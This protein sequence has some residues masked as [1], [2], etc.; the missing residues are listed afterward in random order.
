MNVFPLFYSLYLSFTD[1]SAIA[2]K[3][4]VWVGLAN[5]A[6]ILTSEQLWH[7]FNTTGKYALFTVACRSF[8]ALRWPCW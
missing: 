4:P 8:L 2:K 1:Y 5:Y 6:D 3:A 7:Y